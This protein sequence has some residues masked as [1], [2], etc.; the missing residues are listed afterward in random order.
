[1]AEENIVEIADPEALYNQGMAYYRRRQWR[2][3]KVC[4]EQV[5][6]LQPSRRGIDA[7][8]REL[9]IFLQL[10]SVESERVSESNVVIEAGEADVEQ[11]AQAE[12]LPEVR[13]RGHGLLITFVVFIVS[14]LVVG[15]VYA[16]RQGLLP[17]AS[18]ER[19]KSLRN[20]GQAYLVA[21]QYDKALE[22][23]VKL[24]A[25]APGDPEITNGFDKARGGLYQ[26]ALNQ[27]KAGNIPEAV[28]GYKT[29]CAADPTY[30]DACARIEKLELQQELD[31][32]YQEAR[33]YLDSQAYG[34]AI[35][36]LLKL[37]TMDAEY[38]PGA[39]SEDL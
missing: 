21:Q 2:E 23:Y 8:L 5:R 39:I 27:E 15:L 33:K 25:L 16:Y 36:V 4:F 30:Q 7:L 31:K 11:E 20:L 19:E 34:E 37:R 13:R 12:T 10:E 22:V 9:D 1:M 26:G 24:V 18:D 14:V 32:Q 17:F 35:K 6:A 38:K 29:L 28:Q 3:A